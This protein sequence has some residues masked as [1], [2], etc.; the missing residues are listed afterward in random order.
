MSTSV[1]SVIWLCCDII[2][3]VEA[4]SLVKYSKKNKA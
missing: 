1:A 3:R 4:K 2:T